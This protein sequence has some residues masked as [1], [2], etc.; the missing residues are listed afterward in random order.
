MLAGELYLARDPQ[1]V[2]DRARCEQLN[3]SFNAEA[4]PD[5]RSSLL[6]LLLG[7]VGERV[8][9]RSPFACDYGFNIVLGDG[10]F[11]NFGAVILDCASVVIGDGCQI[12]PGVQLLAA[13]HPR[14]AD[15]RRQGWEM[16][17]PIRLG[18]NVWVGGGV[19]V[20]P[21][22]TIGDDAILGAGSVVTRDIP[23]G[24]LAVGCPARVVR[25]L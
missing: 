9:V 6:R 16:A 5:K 21:G 20:C 3:R 2:E 12:G 24:V 19:I 11:V 23:A 25:E 18:R 14:Q 22:V 8:D 17:E 10:V 4:D 1:L 13:D 15:L 7:A